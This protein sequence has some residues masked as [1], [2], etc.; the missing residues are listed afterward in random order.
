MEFNKG[1]I[2]EQARSVTRSINNTTTGLAETVVG[3]INKW[4]DVVANNPDQLPFSLPPTLQA[5]LDKLQ[6]T[7]AFTGLKLPTVD[8]AESL[9]KKTLGD[10]AK[11]VSLSAINLVKDGEKTISSILSQIEWLG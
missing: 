9:L 5:D 10:L 2:Q 8:Q 3:D 1:F 4:R 11:P 6:N 7:F